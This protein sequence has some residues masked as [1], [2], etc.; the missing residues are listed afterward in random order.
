MQYVAAEGRGSRVVTE[1][2]GFISLMCA[3]TEGELKKKR[4]LLYVGRGYGIRS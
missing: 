1:V 3:R 4:S 2:A